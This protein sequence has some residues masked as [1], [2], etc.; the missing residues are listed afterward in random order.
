MLFGI[1]IW[2]ISF[3]EGRSRLPPNYNIWLLFLNPWNNKVVIYL[4]D[5]Y[6]EMI[7][8]MYSHRMLKTCSLRKGDF[9]EIM[10]A[11]SCGCR[12]LLRAAKA[13]CKWLW[14]KPKCSETMSNI[15]FC[16]N[17]SRMRVI[18]LVVGNRTHLWN[19]IYKGTEIPINNTKAGGGCWLFVWL[20]VLFFFLSFSF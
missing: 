9:T 13:R 19:S 10:Q 18:L 3:E 14:I 15:D 16:Y 4:R 20:F 8:F 5:S 12:L 7:T 2:C 1:N 17:I 11:H 6:L